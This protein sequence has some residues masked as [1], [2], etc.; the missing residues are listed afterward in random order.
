[1][2]VLFCSGLLPVRNVRSSSDSFVGLDSSFDVFHKGDISVVILS[3][4]QAER[5]DRRLLRL[6]CT[7]Q[8]EGMNQY[9]KYGK[10]QLDALQEEL[11]MNTSTDG[12]MNTRLAWLLLPLHTFFFG[13]LFTTFITQRTCPSGK[14]FLEGNH[15]NLPQD[16][17]KINKMILP[18][19]APP[20]TQELEQVHKEI[21]RLKSSLF[22]KCSYRYNLESW[23]TGSSKYIKFKCYCKRSVE[24]FATMVVCQHNHLLAHCRVTLFNKSICTA[25]KLVYT[26]PSPQEEINS[27]DKETAHP[28]KEEIHVDDRDCKWVRDIGNQ[29][30]DCQR[31]SLTSQHR[32]D[33][34]VISSKE[35]FKPTP[36]NKEEDKAIASYKVIASDNSNI[37]LASK[38]PAII[39]NMSHLSNLLPDR[40]YQLP[41]PTCQQPIHKRQTFIRQMRTATA[42]LF[43]DW[44]KDTTKALIKKTI[45][46]TPQPLE[47]T[48]ADSQSQTPK[49][50]TS[51]LARGQRL[52][53]DS[54]TQRDKGIV[55]CIHTANALLDNVNSSDANTVAASLTRG[56]S[57]L[58]HLVEKVTN[59]QQNLT[60]PPPAYSKDSLTGLPTDIHP[61]TWTGLANE[62]VWTLLQRVDDE[63]QIQRSPLTLSPSDGHIHPPSMT[64]SEEI[65]ANALLDNNVNLAIQENSPPCVNN[66]QEMFERT[67]MNES[68]SDITLLPKGQQ[69]TRGPPTK[70]EKPICRQMHP[71]CLKTYCVQ[72]NQRQLSRTTA[73][74]HLT[75]RLDIILHTQSISHLNLLITSSTV[76]LFL[77]QR[78]T[79]AERQKS[80][81]VWLCYKH[82]HNKM[83]RPLSTQLDPNSQ[84]FG[85]L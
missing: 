77:N 27:T 25:Y 83:A 37:V 39:Y 53:R 54:S 65:A 63:R 48:L 33:K 36:S 22:N 1:M 6:T 50:L 13:V 84:F 19:R 58:D 60:S 49:R 31:E 24:T 66:K 3:K 42:H 23:T 56:F 35:E 57:A 47:N 70:K 73:I 10:R 80:P 7:T 78:A 21:L 43:M 75:R 29:Q 72:Q 67:Q 4:E 15:L 45:S 64:S 59:F 30:E 40:E 51:H 20:T 2:S 14:D 38:G 26:Q 18:P 68:E 62:A 74:T 5:P 81:P 41:P 16:P 82:P 9:N 52:G 46:L 11:D 55:I 85:L 69:P 32:A 71:H 61:P 17:A 12:Q 44:R 8:D 28:D 34:D 79:E 76:M